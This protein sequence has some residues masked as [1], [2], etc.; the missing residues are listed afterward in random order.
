MCCAFSSPSSAAPKCRSTVPKVSD[1][2]LLKSSAEDELQEEMKGQEDITSKVGALLVYFYFSQSSMQTFELIAVGKKKKMYPS[3]SLY[4]CWVIMTKWKPSRK[5]LTVGV[6]V[7][8]D[9]WAGAP[10]GGSKREAPPFRTSTP[11]RQS[12]LDR[13]ASAPASRLCRRSTPAMQSSGWKTSGKLEKK[14]SRFRISLERTLSKH[15]QPP[16]QMFSV[17]LISYKLQWFVFVF[18][19]T[20]RKKGIFQSGFYRLASFVFRVPESIFCWSI[21]F[22]PSETENVALSSCQSAFA[23]SLATASQLNVEM[24]FDWAIQT[25]TCSLIIKDIPLLFWFRIILLEGELQDFKSFCNS[26]Q[27]FF[28]H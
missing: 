4:S 17:C 27:V 20:D 23:S 24:D 26:F 16:L 6:N 9:P 2:S 25:P 19:M 1:Q 5:A 21:F 3:S 8:S 14:M 22:R 11:W 28:R 18:Y 10:V 7:L 12:H 13:S 15:S